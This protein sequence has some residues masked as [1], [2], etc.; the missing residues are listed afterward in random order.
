[1]SAAWLIPAAVMLFIVLTVCGLLIHSATVMVAT[2]DEE[3]EAV[4]D[5]AREKEVW[6]VRERLGVQKVP[7]L[8]DW[9]EATERRTGSPVKELI[10]SQALAFSCGLRTDEFGRA[11][12]RGVI[13]RVEGGEQVQALAL[14]A[15]A[16][17]EEAI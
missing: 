11:V 15:I 17:G 3:R 12:V 9:I 7:P 5:R 6:Q 16:D 4:A 2:T 8:R 14:K 13:V 10:V 1:M